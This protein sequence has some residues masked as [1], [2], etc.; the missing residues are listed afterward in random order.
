MIHL[1]SHSEDRYQA[2][3]VQLAPQ[4]DVSFVVP[5]SNE[6]GNLETLCHDILGHSPNGS[7]IEIILVDD[8]STDDSWMVIEALCD[9]Q[10]GIVRGIRFHENRGKAAALSIGFS[11]ARGDVVFTMG[12]SSGDDPAEIPRLLEKLDEGFD[13]VSGWNPA[14]HVRW[15][16]KLYSR[17]FNS[18]LSWCS[19]V[20]LNH[21]NCE[22]KCYRRKIVQNVSLFGEPTC[23]VPAISTMPA[24][25]ALHGFRVTEIPV[26]HEPLDYSI[27]RHRTEDFL[28]GLGDVFS[29]AL[30]R[31]YLNRPSHSA[32]DT[33][34]AYGILGTILLTIA[35]VIGWGNILGVVFLIASL[36][37]YAMGGITVFSGIAC[38]VMIRKSQSIHPAKLV[39]EKAE[40]TPLETPASSARETTS[41][42]GE[43]TSVH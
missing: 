32:N 29:M 33:A 2:A 38:E 34:T 5:V 37:L 6:E 13:M 15:H 14:R 27:S 30:L 41:T 20:K 19:G 8:G 40:T 25:S 7:S 12:I 24:I 17:V 31:G 3:H 23:V 16:Q 21:H 28:R 1:D 18:M 39:A 4:V 11:D 26:S 36:S 43:T 9:L 10:P 35:L 42:V 22:F